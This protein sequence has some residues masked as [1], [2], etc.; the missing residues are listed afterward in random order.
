MRQTLRRRGV[1]ILELL[2]VIGIMA[3]LFALIVSTIAGARNSAKAVGC[4]NNER[5]I[6]TALI[7]FAADHNAYLPV[8]AQVGE[9]SANNGTNVAWAM[10]ANYA[11]SGGTVDL[12]T[13]TLWPYMPQS[14]VARQQAVW[15]PGD[16]AELSQHS[17]ILNTAR[18]FSYSFNANIGHPSGQVSMRLTIK[19]YLDDPGVRLLLFLRWPHRDA[20]ARA[21]HDRRATEPQ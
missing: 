21:D 14:L 7:A 12:N 10:D 16:N 20:F 18:N 5:M 6:Y 2:V 11:S 1:T 9:T 17:G 4:A 15:C 13:G 3:V 19:R 8:P